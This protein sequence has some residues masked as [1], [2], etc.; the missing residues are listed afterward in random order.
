MTR[1]LFGG[2]MHSNWIAEIEARN[3]WVSIDKV[4]QPSIEKGIPPKRRKRPGFC[5]WVVRE[6]LPDCHIITLWS[7]IN[8]HSVSLFLV[9]TP[10]YHGPLTKRFI[11]YSNGWKRKSRKT[12]S[13]GEEKNDE[14]IRN[15]AD[16]SG[17][18]PVPGCMWRQWQQ[19]RKQQRCSLSCY[20]RRRRCSDRRNGMC[21]CSLQLDPVRWLQRRSS[22]FQRP[23]FFC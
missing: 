5:S 12:F 20:R 23:R 13:K 11:F 10:Y 17:H 18:D 14:K 9:L 4:G 1:H 7:A 22:H 8:G 16:G 6:Y 19:R 15:N 21:I 3:S 2:I